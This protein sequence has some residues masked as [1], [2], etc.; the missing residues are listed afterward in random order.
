[1]LSGF[2]PQ[3]AEAARR[4]FASRQVSTAVARI[5]DD[6]S[7]Y[8]FALVERAYV[9]YRKLKTLTHSL[10]HGLLLSC[11]SDKVAPYESDVFFPTLQ[12]ELVPKDFRADVN[13]VPKLVT[14]ALEVFSSNEFLLPYRY[15]K[16]G[17]D[18]ILSLPYVNVGSPRLNK[19]LTSLYERRSASIPAAL[20]KEITRRKRGEGFNINGLNFRGCVNGYEHPIR[21]CTDSAKCDLAAEMRLGFGL[22]ERF[23]YDVSCDTGLHRKTFQLC[24]GRTERVPR[25]ASHLNM[26][27][28]GDFRAG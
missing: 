27:V 12:R 1:M 11:V 21:R 2:S 20:F 19:E 8:Y 22:P 18:S 14:R 9:E 23:E 25:S 13:L 10:I 4:R 15:V 5:N 28:N 24:G 6:H 17:T 26:R 3:V 16:P 7:A